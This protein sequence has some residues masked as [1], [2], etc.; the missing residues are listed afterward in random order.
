MADLDFGEFLINQGGQDLGAQVSEAV[1]EV[2]MGP[3]KYNMDP[4]GGGGAE[5]V[6]QRRWSTLAFPCSKSNIKFS[7]NCVDETMYSSKEHPR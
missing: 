1:I 7:C 6:V 5:V 2:S 3:L 4:A